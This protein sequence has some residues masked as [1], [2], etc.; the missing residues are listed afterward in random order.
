MKKRISACI[1]SIF[2]C[3]VCVMKS[4]NIFG[5]QTEFTSV[6]KQFI[7]EMNERLNDEIVYLE[8]V[9]IEAGYELFLQLNLEVKKT[10]PLLWGL[11]LIGKKTAYFYIHASESGMASLFRTATNSRPPKEQLF[12]F[13]QFKTWQLKKRYKKTFFMHYCDKY[14]FNVEFTL[15]TGTKGQ[16]IIHTHKASTEAFLRLTSLLAD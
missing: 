7:Q 8:M 10:A 12:S 9:Q 2:F 1:I 3:I 5:Q 6:Q 11:L 15:A 16:L 14:S 13:T 4:N